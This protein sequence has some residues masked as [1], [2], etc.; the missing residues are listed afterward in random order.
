MAPR[1]RSCRRAGRPDPECQA[2]A[3]KLPLVRDLLDAFPPANTVKDWWSAPVSRLIATYDPQNP[4]AGDLA[5]WQS[6]LRRDLGKDQA[7]LLLDIGDT[8]DTAGDLLD[9]AADTATDLLTPGPPT[10]PWFKLGLALGAA[11]LVGAA[12]YRIARR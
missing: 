4:P 2:E 1:K 11:A 12:A 9:D 7:D 6:Q 10:F 3:E 8:F 5:G